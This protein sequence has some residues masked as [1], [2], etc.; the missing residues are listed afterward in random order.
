MESAV[1]V[2][3][4]SPLQPNE[5]G[6]RVRSS[7]HM[8]EVG[9]TPQCKFAS[10]SHPSLQFFRHHPRQQLRSQQLEPAS[11]RLPSYID[12]LKTTQK[13]RACIA[14][15]M[16]PLSFST[17]SNRISHAS[18]SQLCEK[19]ASFGGS[20]LQK[21]FNFTSGVFFPPSLSAHL[22]WGRNLAI[23]SLS[24]STRFSGSHHTPEFLLNYIFRALPRRRL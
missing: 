11:E 17:R 22:S 8:F 23:Q 3:S 21:S 1:A 13:T 24:V 18:S 9:G 12:R 4:F 6:K 10:T 19:G 16:W 7:F 20:V 5:I 14:Q 15:S 2:C